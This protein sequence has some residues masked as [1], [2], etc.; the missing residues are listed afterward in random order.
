M[1]SGGQSKGPRSFAPRRPL[2]MIV[3]MSII[4][5]SIPSNTFFSIYR[6][7][8]MVK[9]MVKLSIYLV[10][11]EL[12]TIV[13]LIVQLLISRVLIIV[14]KCFH[15]CFQILITSVSTYCREQQ[16]S[17]KGAGSHTEQ[18]LETV[19]LV[20]GKSK[21]KQV[22]E[23]INTKKTKQTQVQ[24][25]FVQCYLVLLTQGHHRTRQQAY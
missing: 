17:L 5:L 20:S 10:V 3:L 21:E 19:Y 13:F 4:M 22:K 12:N 6:M 25:I 11:N 23:N 16:L 24:L 15:L 18:L 7:L 8:V 9:L 14:L 1:P 2:E